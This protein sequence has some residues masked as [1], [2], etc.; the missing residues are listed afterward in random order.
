MGDHHHT[1]PVVAGD[2]KN[3]HVMMPP[4]PTVLTHTNSQWPIKISGDVQV[5]L[6][7]RLDMMRK[8]HRTLYSSRPCFFFSASAH[9]Q[10]AVADR[11]VS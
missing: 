6:L 3:I 10:P 2:G 7:R 4:Y 1:R 5:I 9:C 11:Q 8:L